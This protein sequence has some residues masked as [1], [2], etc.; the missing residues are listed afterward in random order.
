LTFGE[1]TVEYKYKNKNM[2]INNENSQRLVEIASE[3]SDLLF[4]FK[5]ICKRAMTRGEYEIFRYNTLAHLEPGLLSD[6]EWVVGS[7]IKPFSVIA[8]E[9]IQES[10]SKICPDCHHNLNDDGECDN[11]NEMSIE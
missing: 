9:T 8:D 7:N 11:C 10:I 2:N 6:H 1:N 4:E 3:M 5:D